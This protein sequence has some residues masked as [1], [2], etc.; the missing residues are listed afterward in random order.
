M[1]NVTRFMMVVVS[2][3]MMQASQKA[4]ERQLPDFSQ[5]EEQNKISTQMVPGIPVVP[6]IE[7]SDSNSALASKLTSFRDPHDSLGGAL[8][9]TPLISDADRQLIKELKDQSGPRLSVSE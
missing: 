3:T 8:Q 2:C 1:K 9:R 6:S 4:N 5:G 7:E